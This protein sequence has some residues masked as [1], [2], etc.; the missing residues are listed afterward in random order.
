VTSCGGSSEPLAAPAPADSIPFVDAPAKPL[1]VEVAERVGLGFVHDRGA[2]GKKYFPETM[3]G[4]GGF[5]DYDGDGDLDV[6]LVQG[7][8]LEPSGGEPLPNRLYRNRGDGTF[9]DVTEGSGAGDTGYGMGCAFG[10]VDGDG[11]VD[12][13]VTNFGRN[14]L[15]RNRGGTFE[16][17]TAVAGVGDTG[18]GASCAFA[19]YDADG[20]LDLYVVNYLDFTL[21]THRFCKEK[22]HHVYC[23]PDAYDG[24]PDV[25]YRN[26]G[27]G[28]FVDVTREAGVYVG[29]RGEAKGLGCVWFDHDRDGWLDLYVSNDSTRNFLFRNRGDGSF[30]EI[31]IQAG[32]AYNEWGQTEAGMGVAVGDVDGNGFD[33]LLITHLDMETNTLYRNAGPGGFEDRTK[34]SGV[35]SASVR[36]VGFGVGFLDYDHDGDLDAYVANGHIIDNIADIYPGS[37]YEQRDQLLENVGGGRLVD[38]S[39]RAGPWF[40][41]LRAGRGTAFGDYDEDGDLDVLVMNCGGPVALLRNEVGQDGDWLALRVETATGQ[42]AYGARVELTAGGVTLHRSCLGASS[43]LAQGDPRVHFGLQGLGEIESAV[44]HWPGGEAQELDVSTLRRR[45]VVRVRQR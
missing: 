3:G 44:V 10:D 23:H 17:V 2:T 25:L 35:G 29:G 37:T 4:G 42:A 33:D 24:V 8:P 13:Y 32:V 39:D 20:D 6:Y 5:L 27:D 30:E 11:W 31:G 7:G 9:E 28:R 15:L 38:V 41:E 26:E 1:L 36:W 43:Y 40:A 19:D 21:A 14:T 12:V 22:G 18:W 34:A 45:T 16:D